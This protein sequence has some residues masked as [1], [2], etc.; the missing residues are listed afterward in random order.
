M[1]R[2]KHSLFI[3][4]VL[5]LSL[6]WRSAEALSSDCGYAEVEQPNGGYCVYSWCSGG[7]EAADCMYRDG[8]EFHYIRGCG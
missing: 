5:S 6:S 1:K 8:S 2:L 7:C 4:A 3:F